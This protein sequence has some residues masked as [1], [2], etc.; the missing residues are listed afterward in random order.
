MLRWCFL[1]LLM[2]LFIYL[3][4]KEIHLTCNTYNNSWFFFSFLH[5]LSVIMLQN[6]SENSARYDRSEPISSFYHLQVFHILTLAPSNN[7]TFPNSYLTLKTGRY[8]SQTKH[9]CFHLQWQ[10]ANR[11]THPNL[12][13]SNRTCPVCFLSPLKKKKNYCE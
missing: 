6:P 12:S 3:F 5:I 1:V 10:I 7:D 13:K 2:L 4:F 9:L 8:I 11:S